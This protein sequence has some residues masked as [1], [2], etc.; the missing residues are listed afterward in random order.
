MA[1]YHHTVHYYECDPMG[2]M[3]HSN[4]VRVMEESRVAWM[5]D[6]GF[7]YDRMEAEGITSPVIA[8]D[9][10]YKTPAAFADTLAVHVSVAELGAVRIRLRYEMFV[11]DRL[12]VRATSSHCFIENGRPI[13]LERRCPDFY[14][15][16][17]KNHTIEPG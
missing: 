12:A 5:A 2:I 10:E 17:K 4:Y 7:G 9:L 3:H 6:M 14:E 1:I 8:I 13:S 11:G 16:L 15:V